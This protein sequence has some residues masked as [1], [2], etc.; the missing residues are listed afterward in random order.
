[1]LEEFGNHLTAVKS[2]YGSTAQRWFRGL[3]FLIKLPMRIFLFFLVFIET[4]T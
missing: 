1:M 2:F 3:K 4:P